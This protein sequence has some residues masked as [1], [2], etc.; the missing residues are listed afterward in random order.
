MSIYSIFYEKLPYRMEI[1]LPQKKGKLITFLNPFYIE[2]QKKQLDLYSKFDY[3]CSDGMLPIALNRFWNKRKS[4]RI[5]FDMTSLAKCVFE[6]LSVSQQGTFFIGASQENINKFVELIKKSYS[7][8]ISGWHHGYIKG[9]FDIMAKKIKQSG[10]EIVI[11]GMGAPLQDEFA[12]YL[13]ESGFEGTVYTCGG[14]FHQT[15]ER[16]NYYPEWINRWNLRTFYRLIHERYVWGRIIKYYPRFVINYSLFLVKLHFPK[17][18]GK[19][20]LYGS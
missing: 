19:H 12:V 14:F 15:T 1:L 2:K 10:A 17:Y 18:S 9:K 7:M 6:Y 4:I 16:I 8:N 20:S 5:S 3:I 13:E 11:I